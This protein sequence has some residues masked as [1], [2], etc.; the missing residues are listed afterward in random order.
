MARK[1]DHPSALLLV[2]G[3]AYIMAQL[4][5]GTVRENSPQ[6]PVPVPAETPASELITS[7]SDPSDRDANGR[8]PLHLAAESGK[9]DLIETYLRRGASVDQTDRY[10]NTPLMYAAGTGREKAIQFL[11][12]KGAVVDARNK[13]G[14]TPFLAALFGGHGKAANLLSDAGA[15]VKAVDGAGWTALH[16][17]AENGL[18]EWV[19]RLL[20]LRL[21]PN[22]LRVQ[23]WTPLHIATYKQHPGCVRYLLEAGADPGLRMGYGHSAYDI[24]N[25]R[26]N[27]QLQKVFRE[28]R[29]QPAR[30]PAWLF[31][32][33]EKA[34]LSPEAPPE[35][36]YN[37]H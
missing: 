10:G 14:R 11:I 31:P 2:I 1:S 7:D 4:Y 15:D 19:K 27:E 37:S 20:I 18:D 29:E 26:R 6:Q 23:E 5:L 28:F 17:A 35:N 33:A 22:A 21:N 30:K 9:T 8:S 32:P 3:G 34:P 36:P 16:C 25:G 12:S 13:S 24:A